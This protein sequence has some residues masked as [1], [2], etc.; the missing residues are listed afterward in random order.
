[1]VDWSALELPAILRPPAVMEC[2]EE[3]G[4]G[5][6]PAT[7][8]LTGDIVAELSVTRGAEAL[9]AAVALQR[10]LVRLAGLQSPDDLVQREHGVLLQGLVRHDNLMVGAQ[11]INSA[12]TI[13]INYYG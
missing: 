1:M 2:R 4:V 11:N 12:T 3:H 7:V 13:T 10:A 5:A 9:L 6:A 8:R